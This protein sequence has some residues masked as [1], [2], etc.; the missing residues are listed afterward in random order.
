M[1]GG[2]HGGSR[3]ETGINMPASMQGILKRPLLGHSASSSAGRVDMVANSL[4]NL[5]L[6]THSSH[7]TPNTS[8]GVLSC[9]IGRAYWLF[10]AVWLSPFCCR[11]K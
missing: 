11:E 2:T 3:G 4:R 6:V 7:F 5:L 9:L 8:R 1:M 10:V